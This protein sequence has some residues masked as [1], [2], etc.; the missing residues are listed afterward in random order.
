LAISSPYIIIQ[1]HPIW[2][3]PLDGI[4][5]LL[6]LAGL[7][8]LL[9]GD[10]GVD[11]ISDLIVT[12]LVDVLLAGKHAPFTRLVLGHPA[13]QDVGHVGVEHHVVVVGQD[14]DVILFGYITLYF[15][16]LVPNEVRKPR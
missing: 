10:G 11:V 14:V 9:P 1:I 6:P 4:D 2:V 15:I 5:V 7:D 16:A 3:D 8:L 12:Q 13:Q